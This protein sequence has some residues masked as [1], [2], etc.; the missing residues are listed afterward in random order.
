MSDSWLALAHE[1]MSP[2]AQYERLAEQF[3]KETGIMAPGKDVS[4]ALGQSDDRERFEAWS[5]W[6]KAARRKE[7]QER[8]K[9]MRQVQAKSA[10]VRM[11]EDMITVPDTHYVDLENVVLDT[12][13]KTITFKYAVLEAPVIPEYGDCGG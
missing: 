1:I 7:L 3:F 6:L 9:L 2:T 5:T 8:V 4:P 10:I 11:M 12:D 13:E